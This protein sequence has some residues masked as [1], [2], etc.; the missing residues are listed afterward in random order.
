ME[1]V[2]EKIN[3]FKKIKLES[4]QMIL[5]NNINIDGDLVIEKILSVNTCVDVNMPIECLT[6]E[7]VVSGKLITNIVFACEDGE[8]GSQ[9]S[10]S[11]FSY[12]IVNEQ[13]CI[14]S[15]LNL[16]A[17][18]VNSDVEKCNEK[19]IKVTSTINFDCVLI[20]NL[21]NTYLSEVENNTFIKQEEQEIVSLSDSCCEKF[22]ESL[23]ATVKTGVKKILSTNVDCN[24]KSWETGLGFVQV[25]A[26][27]HAKVLYVDGQEI[28]ELET[29]TVTKN[30][31]QE[32]EF[33]GV[34]KESEVD[35]FCLINHEGV[36]VELA[37]NQE[38]G[39]VTIDITVPIFVCVNEFKS[40]KMLMASDVYST[41][42]VIS[43]ERCHADCCVNLK[44]EFIDKK[45]EGSLFL[46]ESKPRIDKY[47]ATTNLCSIV[48]NHYVKE[49]VLYIEGVASAT[50]IYL[51]DD[52]GGLCSVDIEIPFVVDKEVDCDESVIVE[53]Y[54]HL[55]DEDVS[56]KRGREIYFDARVN[57]MVNLTC[58]KKVQ[59]ITEINNISKLP[60]RE[61]AIEI[62]FAKAGE[63]FW[64]IGKTLKI[65]SEII[66]N[67][68]PEL[69]DPLDK[70][71]NIALYFQKEIKK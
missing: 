30:V 5:E 29:I 41:E 46:E 33:S 58:C 45:I 7:C 24:I 3:S 22:E 10:V 49:G 34:T 9:T 8:V 48:S 42:N 54:V 47:V 35:V 4:E 20:K 27:L 39:D 59:S 52:I 12:K 71:Q 31:K 2:F 53:A 11:S 69:M 62:Y 26:E 13:F 36:V 51:N 70:D 23:N 40:S 60:E 16:K 44:P 67:Q 43:V 50:V 28:S 57:C 63:T 15:K 6:G 14:D 25:E 64:D 56:I 68:N 17:T 1:N 19:L 38:G 32:I 55:M 61:S 66:R 37:E 65:S 21:E 18:C